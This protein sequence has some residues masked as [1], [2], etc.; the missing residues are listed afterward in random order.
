[1]IRA[2]CTILAYVMLVL[3]VGQFM[4]SGTADAGRRRV[5]VGEKMPEFS[6]CDVVGQVF[7]HQHGRGKVLMV[8]FLSGGQ[9]RSILAA[10][11]FERIVGKLG[12][13]RENLEV[14]V[15][16]YDPNNGTCFQSRQEGPARDFHMIFGMIA[17]PT[18][19]I[20]GTDDNVAWVKAGYG[21]DFF[22]SVQLH[23]NSALGIVGEEQVEELTQVQTLANN[24]SQAK[25]RRHL[26]M[27][28][29]LEQKG[30]LESA[31][32]QVHKARQLNPNSIE[33]IL[34]LGQLYCKVGRSEK[35][36]AAVGEIKAQSRAEKAG[37]NLILG[38]ANRQMGKL[39]AAEKF[40]LEVT[41]LDPKSS[42]GFFALGKV[43]Q[44]RGQTDKAIESYHKALAHIFAEPFSQQ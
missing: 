27:S 41:R 1:M 25:T 13:E 22:P 8:V 33:V 35:A 9:K 30:R 32:Q 36:L 2:G 15:V 17:T 4:L 3:A 44:L 39:E 34:R 11:D 29:I 40:L 37:T 21:Y 7:D 31:I 28:A 26:Q 23:L 19:V 12:A 18:V 24:T 10:A 14:V 20:A 16:A 42:R 6:A 5:G 38:W 43:Y